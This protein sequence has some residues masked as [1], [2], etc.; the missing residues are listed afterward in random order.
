[1][2]KKESTAVFSDEE[3]DEL[4]ERCREVKDM[5]YMGSE[6]L[7]KFIQR[8]FTPTVVGLEN[9]PKEPTL[10][11]GNHSFL[12][13]DGFVV[14]PVLWHEANRFAR[15]LGDTAWLQTPRV[16]DRMISNGMLLAHPK[17]CSAMM[18]DGHD[19]LVYPGGAHESMKAA[20]NAYELQ[21]RQRYGF[22]R[23]AAQNGYNITP[24]GVVG[25]E[26]CFDHAMEGDE[27]LDTWLGK[28]LSQR[29]VRPDMVPPVP[30]GVFSTLLPKPQPCYVAFGEPVEVPDYSGKKTVPNSVQQS[31]REETAGRIEDL[32]KDMLLLQAQGR[33]DQSRLRRFLTR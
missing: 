22:V 27:L 15:A 24:F 16:G 31:V 6:K 20:A 33:R 9:I 8:Y 19:L 14:M 18:Q 17:V 1:M 21:W 10:F 29:G 4:I 3:I 12:G 28:L 11:I 13:I 25:P 32:I 7:Y 5:G 30:S 23:M 26:E 2:T